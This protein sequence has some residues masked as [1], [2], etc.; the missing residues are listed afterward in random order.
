MK[1]IKLVVIGGGSSYTPELAEGIIKRYAFLPVNEL[2]LVDIEQGREKVEI[3]YH[4]IKRMFDKAGVDIKLSYTLDRQSALAGADFVLTQFRV[5]G[6]NARSRDEMIPLK[7]NIIGQETT[8]PGGFAKALRTIPVMLQI[9]RDIEKLCPDAWLINFTNPSG[10][11]TEAVKTHSKVKCIGLCN[12]PMNMEKSIADGLGVDASRVFCR[13]TGLNHLSFI[14]NVYLD[15][16]DITE[17]VLKSQNTAGEIVK[18]IPSLKLSDN[19]LTSLGLIPSPY[20]KYFYFEKLMLCEELKSVENG[21]GTRADEVMRVEKELFELYKDPNLSEKPEQLSLRGGALYSDAAM[22][23]VDSIYNNR[24]RVHVVNTQNMSSIPGLPDDCVIETNCIINSS[25]AHPLSCGPLPLN[26]RGLVE[27]VKAYEELTIKAAVQHD[28]AA[29]L[30][31][32]VNNPLVHDVSSAE[33]LLD[34]IIREN[35][36]YLY[37]FNGTEGASRCI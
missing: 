4:L 25:G 36:E 31:A 9:C 17:D 32:L 15:G 13:F 5:G 7:Y 33:P 37:Y 22:S 23:L 16:S 30:M 20:L 14:Q 24:S 1:P 2:V 10:I 27:H 34:D 28:K 3:I 29:A 11:V 18:N 6:L 21:S 8:G 35:Y 19:F 26:I 12:V